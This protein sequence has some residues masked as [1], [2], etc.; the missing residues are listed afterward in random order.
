MQEGVLAAFQKAAADLKA[1]EFVAEVDGVMEAL[2]AKCLHVASESVESCLGPA[3]ETPFH[4]AC[5]ADHI[6]GSVGTLGKDIS[7][8]LSKLL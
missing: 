6:W 2:V 7:A 3:K 4:L 1:E 8:F 5:L